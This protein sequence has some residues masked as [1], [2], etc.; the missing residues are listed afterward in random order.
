MDWLVWLEKKTYSGLNPKQQKLMN[1]IDGEQK[2]DPY[3]KEVS[4]DKEQPLDKLTHGK[5]EEVEK[6]KSWES[7][8]DKTMTYRKTRGNVEMKY[9]TEGEEVWDSKQQKR[10]KEDKTPKRTNKL[11]SWESWLNKTSNQFSGQKQNKRSTTGDG[12]DINAMGTITG[13][14]T[15]NPIISPKGGLGNVSAEISQK[16]TTN[17]NSVGR[18]GGRVGGEERG[19]NGGSG[20]KVTMD[21]T[22][23][24]IADTL[25]ADKKEDNPDEKLGNKPRPPSTLKPWQQK[26]LD[27]GGKIHGNAKKSWELWLNKTLNQ[28][29]GQQEKKPSTGGLGQDINY[30]GGTK[31]EPLTENVP[32]KS[33]KGKLGNVGAEVPQKLTSNPNSASTRGGRLGGDKRGG[34]SPSGGK[35]TMD[36]T[37]A[38]LAQVL[39][40]EKEDNPDEKL[41][42]KPNNSKL[43]KWQQIIQ[44]RSGKIHGNANK[45]WELWL[46]KETN[47]DKILATQLNEARAVTTGKVPESKL[48]PDPNKEAEQGE[49]T[50]FNANKWKSWLIKQQG[51]GD[52]RFGNQHLTGL[53]QEPVADDQDIGLTT[54]GDNHNKPYKESSKEKDE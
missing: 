28:F 41:G 42:N 50:D 16:Y 47:E 13:T 35:V 23:A 4:M 34:D 15:E 25:E 46:N 52:A 20:G 12:S 29:S 7:W 14:Q 54:D 36:S 5:L 37:R 49:I 33:P 10:V 32:I 6:L 24:L 3:A 45:S 39:G 9:P 2:E 11:T 8:L 18:N 31:Q 22:R 26:V 43:P 40:D 44:E 27:Q 51:A 30:M 48:K 38:L 21:S 1:D 53:E 17:P 19:G